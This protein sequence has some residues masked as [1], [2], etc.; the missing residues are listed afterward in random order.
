MA[1]GLCKSSS[2]TYLGAAVVIFGAAV[3]TS[4]GLVHE[5]QDGNMGQNMQA[6]SY[7]LDTLLTRDLT[8]AAG[9]S[10]R[11]DAAWAKIQSQLG[12]AAPSFTV[13]EWQSLDEN[14]KGGDIRS[15][16][17]EIVVIDFWGT[18]CPPCKAAMPK[19]SE[20]ARKYAEKDVRFIGICN[21]RG[22][23]KMMETAEAHDGFFAMAADIDD[24]TKDAYGVQWWPYYVVVDRDGI[25]RAAGIRSDTIGT[26]VD[27]LL[28]LQP[29]QK[30]EEEQ[31]SM[32]RGR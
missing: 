26:V 4:K 31:P 24:K 7:T 11:N 32:G 12:K 25:V 8:Y 5:G 3:A 17:G 16:R 20:L 14:M 9:D 1:C 29:P 15:M 2:V 13:G 23:D 28:E 22:S 21:T 6:K 19:N 27:R 30:K 18:W 10:E